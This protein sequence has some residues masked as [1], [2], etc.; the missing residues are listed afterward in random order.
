MRILKEATHPLLGQCKT[1]L[2]YRHADLSFSDGA[3]REIARLAHERGTGAGGLRTIGY[4]KARG[5]VPPE[6]GPVPRKRG[7]PGRARTRS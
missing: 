3:I 5:S 1:L 4:L 6:Q 7:P 2:K